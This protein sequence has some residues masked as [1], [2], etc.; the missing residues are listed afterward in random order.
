MYLAI[1]GL[2]DLLLS[3]DS[4]RSISAVQIKA[5]AP[6]TSAAAASCHAHMMESTGNFLRS[7][8]CLHYEHN[9]KVTLLNNK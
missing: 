3:K 5:H 7:N 9:V 8:S 4:S 1:H 2:F 6:L